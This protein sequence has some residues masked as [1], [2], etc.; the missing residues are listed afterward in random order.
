MDLLFPTLF[1]NDK[2]TWNGF[3]TTD[4]RLYYNTGDVP[5]EPETTSILSQLDAN[6]AEPQHSIQK[7]EKGTYILCYYP[8][9]GLP[10]GLV[11]A[12]PAG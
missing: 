7:T 11:T 9:S 6:R 3:L 5:W 4:G 12:S 1:Q 2:E 8:L 10:G